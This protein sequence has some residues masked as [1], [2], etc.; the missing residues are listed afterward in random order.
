MRLAPLET[1]DLRRPAL[2]RIVNRGFDYREAA[3]FEAGWVQGDNF[4]PEKK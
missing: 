2:R 4:A 3:R 1:D